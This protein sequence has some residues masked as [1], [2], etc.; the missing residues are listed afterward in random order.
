VSGGNGITRATVFAGG[1]IID[2][3]NGNT[4]IKTA[5]E[6]PSGNGVT[7]I[8]LSSNGSGYKGTPTIQITSSS[9]VP[10]TAYAVM[11]D[12]KT[13]NGTYR[14]AS[15]VISS[16]GTGYGSLSAS[17]ITISGGEPTSE[18]VVDSVTV[19][20]NI[21]GGLTKLGSNTLTLT[22]ALT[23]GGTT[24]I[25]A[26]TL[27]INTSSVDVGDVTLAAITGASSATL[28]VGDGTNPTSLTATSVAV[29]TLT[30]GAG[31]TLTIAAIDG[32]PSSGSAL[33][34]VPE[35]STIVL[36]ALAGL[37]LLIGALR[38]RRS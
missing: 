35:P 4:T 23:Y 15:I 22:G 1:A 26:G 13:G 31:S 16:P 29:G 2:T 7:E 8:A 17:D 6:A 37:G 3:S 5:L 27:Q 33:T 14:I 36:L 10:A 32:G 11:E 28:G 21:S 20:T 30:I 25:Q 19:A 24:D 18:A 34:Q 9:G 12:D 38:N